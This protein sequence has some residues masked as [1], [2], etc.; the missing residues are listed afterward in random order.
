[1]GR[2]IYYKGF[3][4]AN[5]K[6]PIL[7][8]HG[9][10]GAPHNYTLSMSDLANSGY[11][12]IFY[13]QLGVGKSEVPKDVTLFTVERYVEE[14][15]ELRKQLKLKKF[16]LWGSSWGGFLAIAYALKYQENLKTLTS[17]GGASS[18]LLTYS[19]MLRLKSEMPRETIETL[20]KYEKEADYENP[21]YIKALDVVYRKHLCRLPQWPE[22][23][24]YAMNHMSK[25]VYNTMWCPNEF[26]MWGNLMYWDVT[27]KLGSIRTPTLLT[28]GR[29]DEVTP[30]VQEVLRE[31]I[32]GSD[33][34]IFEESSHLTFWEEREKYMN[35]MIDFLDH[36]TV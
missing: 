36:T 12:V 10:P 5:S 25:P 28:C 7:C 13:D 3:G 33:L 22:E 27:S 23:V 2:K 20:Q 29:Y 14:L 19:E 34:Q 26:V 15:E 16:H 32:P 17:A 4:N 11:Y 9:G 24:T 35:A 30:K 31:G 21:E 18:T 6:E 1:M 8:L